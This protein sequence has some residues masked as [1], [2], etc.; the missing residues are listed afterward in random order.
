MPADDEQGKPFDTATGIKITM[1]KLS[2]LKPRL[3]SL[4]PRLGYA[5]GDEKA[6]DRQRS[7]TQPWRAWYWHPRWR[8]T[9]KNSY[10]D[11]LRWRILIRDLFTC[12]MCK[13]MET[14]D[15]LL[16]VDHRRPHR[17]DEGLFWDEGNL[18]TLC[19][20][21]HDSIKQ[22]MDRTGQ[23]A[24]FFPRWLK[25]SLIPLT[26]V[27]G[28]P[29]SGKSTYA[30]QHAGKGDLVIDLDVIASQMSGE[31]LH[32]WSR[33]KWLHPAL[34]RR[35]DMLGSLARPSPYR[36]AWFIVSE[37]KAEHRKFWADHLKP[38]VIIVIE[39]PEAQCIANASK[40]KD[41]DQK[42]TAE[43]IASWWSTYTRR[44][45]DTTIE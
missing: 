23:H 26:I 31:P 11:G 28:P 17:G 13:R 24:S 34:F 33:E 7:A 37:P 45:G 22:R 27:C 5:A 21:C 15:S 25:P 20:T 32:T 35:N 44:A 42:R 12:C 1:A 30:A 19:K 43:A 38:S 10:Q 16:V 41:R 29:A 18:Q 8:G 39:T 6:R 2:N 9:E 36:A 4:A 3:G 14:N 40:D